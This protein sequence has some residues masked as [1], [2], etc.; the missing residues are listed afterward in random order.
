LAQRR[1]SFDRDTHTAIAA[2][3][4]ADARL[5]SLR[6]PSLTPV[7]ERLAKD[8]QSLRAVPEPDHAGILARLSAIDAQMDK[9]PL[10]GVLIGERNSEVDA[11]TPQ[12][13][14]GRIGVAI[15]SAF[16]QLFSVRR[17]DSSHGA[18][19]SFEEQS[20]RRQHMTLLTFAARHALMRSDQVGYRTA[21][22]ES[23][24][25]LTQYFDA[26]PSAAAASEE[27]TALSKLNI[28]PAL[29]DVSGAGQL[30]MHASATAQPAP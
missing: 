10:K 21:L 7:R 12:S 30:L 19:V 6:E 23:L 13:F 11:N 15:Q 26:S 5:A 27:L 20:L 25:W 3:E 2:L 16:T 14:F 18:I 22:D 17:V 29:P 9:A 28:A 8:L 24:A 1:L 4:S